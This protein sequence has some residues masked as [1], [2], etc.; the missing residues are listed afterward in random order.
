MKKY[1]V[2][3]LFI[4]ILIGCKKGENDPSFTL[5][6]RTNRL[7]GVWQLKT[8]TFTSQDTTETFSDNNLIKEYG[9]FTSDPLQVLITYE[10]ESIGDYTIQKQYTYPDNFNNL[11]GIAYTWNYKERGIWNFAGGEGDIPKKSKLLLVPDYFEENISVGGSNIEAISIENPIDGYL[12]D[13]DELRK[14]KLVL[15]YN[16]TLNTE[17]GAQIKTGELNLNKQ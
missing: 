5:L 9:N 1:L 16:I 6:S 17:D 11:G 14:D 12:F 10:F 13:I 3:I 4:S 7:S 8:A 2:Y 15:K